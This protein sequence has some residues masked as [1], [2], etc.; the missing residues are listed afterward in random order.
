M[1]AYMPHLATDGCG[2]TTCL[3]NETSSNDR[4]GSRGGPGGQGGLGGAGFGRFLETFG[5]VPVS[6]RNLHALLEAGEAA[7]LY[8]GG[9]REVRRKADLLHKP[10]CNGTRRGG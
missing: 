7:L 8:P 1:H 5:A 10:Y 2:L 3:Q 6:G 9:A 4:E